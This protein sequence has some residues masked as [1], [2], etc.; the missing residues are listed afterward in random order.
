MSARTEGAQERTSKRQKNITRAGTVL[1]LVR[2][3]GE[4]LAV[5]A[6]FTTDGRSPMLSSI[7]PIAELQGPARRKVDRWL[8]EL[9]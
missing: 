3:G 8:A 6:W 5:V 2:A 7:V 1:S 4:W 9:A